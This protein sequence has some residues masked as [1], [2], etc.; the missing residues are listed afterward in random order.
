MIILWRFLL[1]LDKNTNNKLKKL[2]KIQK[3]IK[4]VLIYKTNY[5][6]ISM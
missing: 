3:I 4:L 1:N 5:C 6:S 2:K